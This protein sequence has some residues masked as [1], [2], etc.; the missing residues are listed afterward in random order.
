MFS[1]ES[2]LYP[3]KQGKNHY[4]KYRTE[5]V[6]VDYGPEDVHDTRKNKVWGQ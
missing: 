6:D 2:D 3:D 5:H 4:R 1:N